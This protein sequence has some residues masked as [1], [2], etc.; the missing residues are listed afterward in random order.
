MTVG[1]IAKILDAQVLCLAEKAGE[2][3]IETACGCDLMSDVLSYMS[4]EGLLLTGLLNTQV[5]R[6]AEMMDFTCIVFVRG[7]VP[8]KPIIEL[9]RQKGIILLATKLRMY[10]ACGELYK[11]GLDPRRVAEK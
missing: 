3:V 2:T 6:T 4:G 8:D 10:H 7:K 11:N 1:E 9:A 5:V